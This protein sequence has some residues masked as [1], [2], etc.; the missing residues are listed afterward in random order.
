M[1]QNLEVSFAFVLSQI[2]PPLLAN[3]ILLDEL[4]KS[5][6]KMCDAW[7]RK[8]CSQLVPKAKEKKCVSI[9]EVKTD[10]DA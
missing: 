3:P 8:Q 9:F 1:I 5:I 10:I 7:Y 4:M 2:K 6:S